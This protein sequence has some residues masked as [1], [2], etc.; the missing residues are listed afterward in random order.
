MFRICMFTILGYL[1][2]S[3]LYARLWGHVLCQKDIADYS[4][5]KNPGTA[6]AFLY[7]NFVCG[8]LTLLCDLLKGFLPVRL[9]FGETLLQEARQAFVLAAPV[10]GHTFSLFHGFHG[11]KGIAVTFGCL[12]G[13]YPE[14]R[15]LGLLVFFF[16][17]FSSILR[18]TPH[19]YRTAAAYLGT[20]AAM[21]VCFG[22]KSA[23]FIGFFLITA[24]VCFRLHESEEPREKAEVRL[25]WMR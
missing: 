5:D 3:V 19:F 21:A 23:P 17:F 15:P 6:N 1:S 11:G 13:L 10:I 20:L 8:L 18:I 25:L 2:G 22:V 4:A 16:L 9:F 7:G 14:Y 12:I 24:A